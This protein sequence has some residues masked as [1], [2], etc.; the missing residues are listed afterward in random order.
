MIQE[1]IKSPVE[2]VMLE[3]IYYV[4]LKCLLED[5][6]QREPR[7]H[8]KASSNKLVRDDKPQCEDCNAGP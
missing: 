3:W 4:R 8:T 5:Y 7:G 6:I 1:G 2:I